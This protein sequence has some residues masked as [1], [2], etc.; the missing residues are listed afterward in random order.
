MSDEEREALM[1]RM[2]SAGTLSETGAALEEA[3]D[4]LRE[5][6]GDDGVAAAM[7]RLEEKQERLE[8]S[9]RTPNWASAVV[10]V[11]SALAVWSP[12]YVL[13]G[14]W[15]FSVLAGLVLGLEISWWT[16][17][18]TLAFVERTRRNQSGR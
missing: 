16:R 14:S 3:R 6:P 8:D 5:H 7:Q 2:Q 11:A 10:F 15:T 4:W 1:A 13:S 17:E 18:I 9:K 12:L